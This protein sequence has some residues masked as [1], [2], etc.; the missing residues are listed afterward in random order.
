LL[1]FLLT[2]IACIPTIIAI[3]YVAGMPAR[4][5]AKNAQAVTSVYEART[6][7]LRYKAAVIGRTA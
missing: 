2:L 5:I 4:V 1:S 3:E 6:A 7:I